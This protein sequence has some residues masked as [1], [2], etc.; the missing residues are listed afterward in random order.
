MVVIHG[1]REGGRSDVRTRRTGKQQEGPPTH[2][3]QVGSVSLSSGLSGSDLVSPTSGSRSAED[4]VG[5]GT[6]DLEDQ[7]DPQNPYQA[8]ETNLSRLGIGLDLGD[9]NTSLRSSVDG[10]D[11]GVGESR[12]LVRVEVEE[13][14]LRGS[15]GL[16]R[17]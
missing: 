7:H 11:L 13:V 2:R 17:S 1:R 3:S 9:G 6:S 8:L 16:L 15:V 12:V 4:N 10:D 5:T 14:S